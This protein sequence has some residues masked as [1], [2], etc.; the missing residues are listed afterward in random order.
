M[1]VGIEP[2]GRYLHLASGIRLPL[3]DFSALR[4]RFSG[5]VFLV[6]SGPSVA[7]FPM[8]RFRNWPM[9]AMNG[10]I[11][12]FLEEEIRPLFYLCDDKGVAQHKA[13]A[14]ADGIRYSQYAA[15]G[16][17]SLEQ[18]ELHS[19]EV[20]SEEKLFLLERANRL[21][22]RVKV[23]DRLFAWRNRNNTDMAVNW[24]LLYQKRNRIG[25]SRDLCLGYFNARTI[26]YAALQL[27]CHLGFSR[28]FMVGVDMT[29]SLGQFYDPA[30]Q[31]VPS[32]LDDDWDDYILP[33]FGLL[34]RKVLG[35][36]FQVFNLSEQSRIP[37]T[38]VPK[39]GWDQ[40]EAALAS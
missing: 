36:R 15:L 5:S 4:G 1:Q 6:A 33:S 40:L 30:G 3:G 22:G 24:S 27:A 34:S 39:L 10:S 29:P 21:H 19:P 23:S 11:K 37:A 17:S 9:L 32:R 18:V 28:V 16:L 7:E 2:S 31:V 35:A 14:V 13:V 25:F 38:L 12:R 20:L 26:A 8:S